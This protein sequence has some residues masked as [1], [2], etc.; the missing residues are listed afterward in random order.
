MERSVTRGVMGSMEHIEARPC[1]SRLS[2]GWKQALPCPLG[3]KNQTKR[4]G[5][6]KSIKSLPSQ[7]KD[8]SCI[9]HPEPMFKN[10]NTHTSGIVQCAYHP[11]TEKA[12]PGGSLGLT[13][14]PVR[15]MC[16][17]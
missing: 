16:R 11:G 15:W 5:R 7:H 14:Q 13:G 8:L 1:S 3:V 10:I 9:P 6:Q 12:E 4:L 17:D 2:W